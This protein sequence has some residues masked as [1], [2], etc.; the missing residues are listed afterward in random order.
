MLGKPAKYRLCF[1][2]PQNIVEHIDFNPCK[3]CDYTSIIR[4]IFCLFE[5]FWWLPTRS[6]LQNFLICKTFRWL[7]VLSKH[8]LML[9]NTTTLLEVCQKLCKAFNEV[10]EIQKRIL[11]AYEQDFSKHAPNEIVPKIRM[12]WQDINDFV[13]SESKDRCLIS[14]IWLKQHLNQCCLRRYKEPKRMDILT[15]Q[16]L[17]AKR[18]LSL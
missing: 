11:A 15:L 16:T 1:N 13:E 12:L 7:Q 3:K 6:V 9:W 8:M 5:N 18:K 14:M 2:I 10:R 17:T 4:R